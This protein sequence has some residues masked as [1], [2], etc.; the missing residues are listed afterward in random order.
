MATTT[1]DPTNLQPTDHYTIIS[2]D[3]HAGANHETYREY[4]DQ[5]YLDDFDAWR[6]KY[7]NPC[8][9]LH[10]D[11]GRDPQLGQRAAQ[12]ATR[13]AD[14][15]VGEV[16]FPNTVPPFFPSFVLFARPAEARRVRAPARRDPRPQP[17]ARRLLRPSTPSG[18]PASARS[19]STT[20][21]TRSTTSAGSR[22]TAC[23]A[24]SCCP[25]SRPTS[26]G[27]KPL[28]DPVYDPLWEVCEELGVAV[29]SHGGTGSPDYGQR[30]RSPLLMI[31]EIRF[32]SQRPF[33]HMLLS[34]VFE[35]FPKLQFVHHRARRRVGPADARSS[36]TT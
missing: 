28:Y 34:G 27:C 2:A 4:L 35:R 14:G 9:D 10:G 1:L 17:L 12:R 7:K 24:A 6:N 23:A 26:R 31:S 15:V 36:S 11:D 16:I 30:A 13:S 29:N 5:E 32:Y 33:V 3:C 8:K 22:S 18:A 19:S 21:T 20:S 25:R